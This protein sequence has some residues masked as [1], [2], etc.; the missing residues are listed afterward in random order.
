MK[1]NYTLILIAS[2][3]VFLF[4]AKKIYDKLNYYF[5]SSTLSSSTYKQ[6]QTNFQESIETNKMESQE[7]KNN[8]NQNINYDQTNQSFSVRQEVEQPQTKNYKFTIRYEN[9]KAKNVKL[10]GSFWAWKEREMKKVSSGVWEEELVLRDKGV[11]KYYFIVDGK[12]VL[13]PK[14]KT[15]IDGK[16]SVFEVR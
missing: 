16:F 11:Y 7:S 13:D 4:S 6:E 1:T 9:R 5:Y 14:A 12:K 2:V 10:S 8:E 15:T 3:G